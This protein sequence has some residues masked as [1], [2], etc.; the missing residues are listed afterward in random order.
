MTLVFAVLVVALIVG[1]VATRT[2]P[3]SARD[4]ALVWCVLVFLAWALVGFGW[5]RSA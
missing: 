1:S 5:V 3:H 2:R 4:W